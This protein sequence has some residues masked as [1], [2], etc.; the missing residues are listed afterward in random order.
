[1][2]GFKNKDYAVWKGIK[3]NLNNREDLETL[4]QRISLYRSINYFCGFKF[5]EPTEMIKYIIEN[6]PITVE[7]FLSEFNRT[8]KRTFFYY[9]PKMSDK[10]KESYVVSKLCNYI[11]ANGGE[12]IQVYSNESHIMNQI[13][14]I[15]KERIL[16]EE[17]V[18]ELFEFELDEEIAVKM[19]IEY[20]SI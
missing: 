17:V 15:S 8:E 13:E 20:I 10:L 5:D 16:T 18:R 9:L 3:Y 12:V 7:E 1:M 6:N 19:S 14:Y 11:D 2:F 4:L